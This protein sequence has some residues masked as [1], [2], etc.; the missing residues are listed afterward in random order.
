MAAQRQGGAATP[1]HKSLFVVCAVFGTG[2]SAVVAIGSAAFMLGAVLTV[3]K[4][5]GLAVALITVMVATIQIIAAG[6]SQLIAFEATA[7]GT[8][9]LEISHRNFATPIAHILLRL[10]RLV[11]FVRFLRCTIRG[12]FCGLLCLR[13]GCCFHDCFIGRTGRHRQTRRQS[14][15]NCE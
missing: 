14:K 5:G 6:F 11:G 9:G 15:N 10:C 2:P 7:V 4:G 8:I 3:F 12:W 13:G 1:C